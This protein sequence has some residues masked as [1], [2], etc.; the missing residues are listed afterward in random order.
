VPGTINAWVYTA[1]ELMFPESNA[2]HA[3]ALVEETVCAAESSFVQVTVLFIPITNVILSS[4]YPG[5]FEGL[6]APLYIETRTPDSGEGVLDWLLTVV[7][8]V[9][10]EVREDV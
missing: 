7:Q 3:G 1:P 2:A 9:E 4:L 6:A 5:A 10:P 8:E